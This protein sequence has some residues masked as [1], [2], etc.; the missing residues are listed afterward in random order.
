MRRNIL[1]TIARI[2]FSIIFVV[3]TITA[4]QNDDKLSKE[5]SAELR[6]KAC[7]TESVN[8]SAQ[9]DKKQRPMPDAPTDKALIYVL[10]P[11]M[12][13]YKI[14]SKFAVNGDWLG[15]NR[16]NTYFFLTLEPGE[17]FFCSESENQSYL[18]LNLE[19]GKTYYLQQKVKAGIWKARTELVVMDENTGKKKL[20]DVNLS[21]FTRKN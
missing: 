13:G 5:E 2:G 7:G 3:A 15:V 16:G 11:T 17:H 10:R 1:K 4:Q 12:I 18:A 20:N 9:T 8:F 6:S 19:A 14:H 21:V